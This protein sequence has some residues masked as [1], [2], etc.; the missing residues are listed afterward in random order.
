MLGAVAH[1]LLLLKVLWRS[2]ALRRL[3]LTHEASLQ[4]Q[5]RRRTGSA[6]DLSL[7]GSLK[8]LPHNAVKTWAR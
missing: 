4:S 7:T 1:A 3:V 2:L 6:R 5:Q 8:K